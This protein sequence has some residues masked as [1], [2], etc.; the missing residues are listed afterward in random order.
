MSIAVHKI[1]PE[2]CAR[3]L[4]LAVFPDQHWTPKNMSSCKSCCKEHHR[5]R[6]RTM[7]W[8]LSCPI[9][10]CNALGIYAAYFRGKPL[11]N[12]YNIKEHIKD[13]PKHNRNTTRLLNI[14]CWSSSNLVKIKMMMMIMGATIHVSVSGLMVVVTDS[15]AVAHPPQRPNTK[16]NDDEGQFYRWQLGKWQTGIIPITFIVPRG[17]QRI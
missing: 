14:A 11:L 2:H 17:W 8:I 7:P 5:T 15:R 16:V 10:C 12:S 3:N 9:F 13:D 4:L 6:R 1:A